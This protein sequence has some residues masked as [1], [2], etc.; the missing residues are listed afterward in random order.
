MKIIY[1]PVKFK[2]N[3]KKLLESLKNYEN[4][5]ITYTAQYAHL[6]NNLK[7]SALVLGC[8]VKKANK[9]KGKTII[10]VGDGV[11]HALMIKKEN[12][13]KKVIILNP[14]DLTEKEVLESDV[15]NF[16]NREFIALERLKHAKKVGIIASTKPGQERIKT[17]ETIKKKLE[18]QGKIVYLFI[19]DSINPEEFMNY[20]GL[21][22]LINTACSRIGLDDYSKFNKPVINYE[23][24]LSKYF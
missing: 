15:K 9:F 5:F 19:A 1:E 16:I 24:V 4:S 17:C 18:A 20:S 10:F 7:N 21:D 14:K 23:L 3:T 8:N 11:F 13:S 2:V 22:I 6:F 12:L